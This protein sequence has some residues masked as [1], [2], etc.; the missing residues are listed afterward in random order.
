MDGGIE[1]NNKVINESICC[2]YLTYA[3][4]QLGIYKCLNLGLFFLDHAN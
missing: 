3:G 2:S 4:I 1:P